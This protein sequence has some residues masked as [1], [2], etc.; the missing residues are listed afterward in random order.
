MTAQDKYFLARELLLDFKKYV[1]WIHKIAQGSSYDMTEAHARLCDKLQEYAEGKNKK[2]NLMVN[3]SPGFGKS[4]LIQYFIT[5]CFARSKHCMFCYIA[6]G[7]RL[8]KKLS[9]ESRNLM[10]MPEW[11]E[12]FGK[13]MDP[14]DK[15]VLNYHLISGGVRSGLTAGTISSAILGLDAGNPSSPDKYF[16]GA[17]ILDDVNSPEVVRS[18]HEQIEAPETYQRKLATR[19]R[20]P[21]VPTICIMQRHCFT[22]DTIIW[23]EDG[24]KTIKDVVDNKYAGRVWSF[25]PSSKK[26]ELKEIEEYIYNPASRQEIFN[27]SGIECTGEHRMFTQNGAVSARNVKVGDYIIGTSDAL[28]CGSGYTKFLGELFLPLMSIAYF[29]NFVFGKCARFSKSVFGNAGNSAISDSSFEASNQ[30]IWQAVFSN[31]SFDGCGVISNRFRQFWRKAALTTNKGKMAI[32]LGI[33]VIFPIRAV[34]QVIKRI[35]HWVI[36]KMAYNTTLRSWANKCFKN[37]LMNSINLMITRFAKCYLGVPTTDVGCADKSSRQDAKHL[38]GIR[39]TVKAF[40]ANNILK[41]FVHNITS[42]KKTIKTTET[43]CVAVK[44]NHTLIVGETQGF[45]FGNCQNDFAGWVKKNE[46]DEW[47]WFIVPAID[48]EGKSYYESRYPISE[49]QRLQQQNPFMFAAMYQ[50]EPVENYGA[51]FHEDWIK[52][53]RA[54]PEKFQKVFIT[55]DFGFT[56]TGDKS[57]FVCWGLASDNNLYQLGSRMGK[58][59]SPDAKKYCVEFFRRCRTLYKQLRRVYVENTL[60]GIGFIQEMKREC[61]DMAIVPLKRGAKKNKLNRAESAMTWMEAGRVYFREADPNFVAMRAELLAYNPADKNP[62]DEWCF[63]AGTK[64][65]TIWGE[66]P[67]EDIKVGDILWT[68]IGWTKVKGTGHREAEVITKLGLTGTS[69]HKIWDPVHFR[70]DCLGDVCYFE[71]RLYLRSIKWRVMKSY[72]IANGISLTK[73]QDI[74]SSMT[75]NMK[76]ELA[77]PF[78]G[79]FGNFIREKRYLRAM[80]FIILTATGVITTTLTLCALA[81]LSTL[82]FIGGARARANGCKSILREPKTLSKKRVRGTRAKK[83]GKRLLRLLKQVWTRLGR[84]EPVCYAGDNLTTVSQK[85]PTTERSA[86]GVKTAGNTKRCDVVYTIKTGNGVYVANSRLVSNCDN[87]GDATELAFNNKVGSIFL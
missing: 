1:L 45:V 27:I 83:V 54:T 6:Y 71:P 64:I 14:G 53:F 21:T 48:A 22:P 47:E 80:L 26:F 19:R 7:D 12:L 29:C 41:Y 87:V 46:P 59:E 43:Y 56:S 77:R 34:F 3:V 10:M 4:L 79:L 9:R 74:I 2:R 32:L 62:K 23:T 16:T 42:V 40:I 68:P 70:F 86:N 72:L 28:Y 39:N 67:I 11:E 85:T 76:T 63:V 55:T 52:T 65:M 13:E 84:Q 8:I 61:P 20:M 81:L 69:D 78:I 60:S 33:I 24:K 36:V 5:W 17:L 66:R 44:D 31:K 82:G 57:L 35:V 75:R 58:W 50:Q 49:L 15:S 18:A 37:K 30:R 73:R 38:A 51:Y 25:N